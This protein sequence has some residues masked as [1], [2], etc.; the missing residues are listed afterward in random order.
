M[1]KNILFVLL[2]GFFVIGK[3]Y[4]QFL[5]LVVEAKDGTK[6]AFAFSEKPML[7]FFRN[8]VGGKD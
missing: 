2:S 5:N 8:R 1:R 3:A 4:G 7:F 6:V